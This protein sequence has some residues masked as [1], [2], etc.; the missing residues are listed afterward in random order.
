MVGIVKAK[1]L[2][3]NKMIFTDKFVLSISEASIFTGISQ[4]TIKRLI[5]IN[6]FVDGIKITPRRVVFKKS[7][8]ENWVNTRP[9]NKSD[10]IDNKKTVRCPSNHVE[11]NQAFN[12]ELIET[13]RKKE[14]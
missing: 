2:K 11:L 13:K 12:N 14:L 9:K 10:I 1:N 6:D 4:S 5:E 3:E 7:D 8:I